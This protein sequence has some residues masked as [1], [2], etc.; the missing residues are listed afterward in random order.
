MPVPG[1]KTHAPTGRIPWPLILLEGQ[2]KSGRS[3][4]IAE[5]SKSDKIGTLYWIDLNEGAAEEYGAIPGAN[6]QVVELDTGDYHELLHVQDLHEL[7]ERRRAAVAEDPDPAG[8]VPRP[9]DH[10]RP[11]QGGRGDRPGR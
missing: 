7:V 9:G 5:F 11:R 1:L 6:Y 2:E 8:H 3:W 4:S 10:H